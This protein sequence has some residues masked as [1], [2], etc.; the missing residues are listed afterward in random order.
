[1]FKPTR[2]CERTHMLSFENHICLTNKQKTIHLVSLEVLLRGRTAC[3]HRDEQL[4]PQKEKQDLRPGPTRRWGRHTGNRRRHGGDK[5]RGQRG[6][7]AGCEDAMLLPDLKLGISAG[8]MQDHG[9][10]GEG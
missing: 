3:L 8:L 2:G 4:S 7:R 10:L 9:M 5:K 1:M 6:R